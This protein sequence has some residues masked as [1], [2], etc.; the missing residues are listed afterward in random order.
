MGTFNSWPVI[1]MP[2]TPAP[3]SLEA[4]IITSTGVAQN[5]FN[6][7][8]Q[9]QSWN[10]A[11]MELTVTMP[12]MDPTTFAPWQAFVES[13]NGIANVFQ[14][15]GTIFQVPADPGQNLTITDLLPNGR[16]TPNPFLYWRLTTNSPKYSIN[17]GPLYGLT[18]TART[19]SPT[20]WQ[21]AGS[22]NYQ[23][24]PDITSS[25]PS[26]PAPASLQITPVGL[27]GSTASDFSGEMLTN[28]WLDQ[29]VLVEAQCTMPAMDYAT[30]QP[31]ITFL[32]AAS[33]TQ[34]VFQLPSTFTQRN[35]LNS[36]GLVPIELT[37]SGYFRMKTN[38]VKWS[39]SPGLIYNVSFEI[40]TAL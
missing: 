2:S 13:C 38:T 1:T 17:V 7:T 29:P 33:G 36:A 23:G 5:P 31:W 22:G 20:T 39:I 15:P 16:N 40:R 28:P 34:C 3:S 14:L 32:M 25:V 11:W 35:S 8:W 6:A 37:P 10:A 12:P 21:A 19:A 27:V 30:A 24:W 18:F 4:S 9:T 26:T